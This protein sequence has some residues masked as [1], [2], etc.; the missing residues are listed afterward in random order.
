[1]VFCVSGMLEGGQKLLTWMLEKGM[2]PNA[3]THNS[4]M[5]QYCIRNDMRSAIE[6]YRGMGQLGVLPDANSYN[7]MIRGH[8]KVRNMK[9]AWFCLRK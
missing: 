7:I 6:T 3:T 1:M 5:K 4:L 8:C 9:E 2:M